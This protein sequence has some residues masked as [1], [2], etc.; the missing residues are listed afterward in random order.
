MKRR[1]LYVLM[2]V[3]IEVYST[4]DDPK[5]RVG[6]ISGPIRDDVEKARQRF[7]FR[8]LADVNGVLTAVLN[9]GYFIGE[10][11]DLP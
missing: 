5:E 8:H 6:A 1:K 11:R 3:E 10:Q 2:P 9:L 4:D 7:A